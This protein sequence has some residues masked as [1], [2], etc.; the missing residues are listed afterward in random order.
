MEVRPPAAMGDLWLAAREGFSILGLIDGRFG[1]V[2]SPWHQ[3]ILAVLGEGVAVL[4]AA[5]MGALRA[6]ELDRYGMIGIG[7][8]Y[9]W[10]RTGQLDA[11]DEVAVVHGPAETGYLPGSVAQVDVRATLAAARDADLLA[12]HEVVLLTQAMSRIWFPE[13]TRARLAQRALE[14]L[15]HDRAQ[16]VRQVC[17]ERWVSVKADDARQLIRAVDGLLED[18]V[19]AR[20]LEPFEETLPWRAA[21]LRWRPGQGRADQAR[22]FREQV[23]PSWFDRPPLVATD[24]RPWAMSVYV[25]ADNDL[26]PDVGA[27]IDEMRGVGS[28]PNVH[29]A[30]QVHVPSTSVSARFLVGA[31]AHS[32]LRAPID[33]SPFGPRDSGEPATLTGFLEWSLA[34]FPAD[35]RVLVLWGHGRGLS[36]L[37]DDTDHAWIDLD[38]LGRA[39]SIAGLDTDRRLALLGFDACM[40]ATVEC[41]SESAPFTE[42]VVASQQVVPNF[43]WAYGAL[44]EHLNAEIP[45]SSEFGRLVVDSYLA[46]NAERRHPDVDMALLD[47]GEAD[48][49]AKALGV[50]GDMLIPQLGANARA[51]DSA[52]ML[53]RTFRNGDLVDLRDVVGRIC[54]ACDDRRLHAA[55]DRTL[56]ALGKAVAHAGSIGGF[57]VNGAPQADQ[58]RCGLSVFW[59]RIAA[60]WERSRASYCRMRFARTGGAGWVRFL[61]ALHKTAA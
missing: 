34:G 39:L 23:M 29:V 40:M 56:E 19:P 31:K 4:G 50:L 24:R 33:I 2:P 47:A 1:D 15:G 25:G 44:L 54:A 28:S 13:R 36:V 45:R 11:D 14:L 52:R 42:W 18:G 55:A 6:A 58:R 3:E 16:V 43:G 21:R 41:L 46:G 49:L 8:V 27:D 26:E 17:E 7:R 51:F 22:Y 30:G 59:P 10:Y 57:D 5:S 32:D 61:D 37:G 60:V 53:A 12:T 9:D 38:E 35:R 48:D 20:A